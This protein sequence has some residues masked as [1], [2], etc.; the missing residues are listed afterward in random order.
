MD[1]PVILFLHNKLFSP[2]T[3]IPKIEQFKNGN[4]IGS[5]L[6]NNGPDISYMLL[7]GY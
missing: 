1:D 4:C 6:D 7:S 2:N 3:P 5:F